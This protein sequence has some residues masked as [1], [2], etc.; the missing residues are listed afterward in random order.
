MPWRCCAGAACSRGAA[1]IAESALARARLAPA[2]D[3]RGR[4]HQTR[5]GPLQMTKV[6]HATRPPEPPRLLERMEWAY[7]M[8]AQY[9]L[10]TSEGA[11]LVRLAFRAASG[12]VWESQPAIASATGVSRATVQRSLDR[13]VDLGLIVKQR[14]FAKTNVYQLPWG[15][16]EQTLLLHHRDASGLPQNAAPPPHSDATIASE[17]GS[18]TSK[19]NSE[20]EEEGYRG[21]PDTGHIK[22]R[23]TEDR[24]GS[25]DPAAVELWNDVLGVLRE[26][27]P[28]PSF[29]TWFQGTMGYELVDI[30]EVLVDAFIANVEVKY[31]VDDGDECPAAGFPEGE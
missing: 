9:D 31:L 14:R 1:E 22:K 18:L 4:A 15:D 24:S 28:K 17:R 5:G 25:P 10:S 16:L 26:C 27:I 7:G 6:A 19:G 3:A 11:V 29:D 13:L 12:S 20:K 23:E 8:I 30:N 2:I 21:D